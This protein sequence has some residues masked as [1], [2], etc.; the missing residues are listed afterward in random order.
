MNRP[1]NVLSRAERLEKLTEAGKWHE[2]DSIF[3][4]PKVKGEIKIKK[5]K[6]K[7]KKEEEEE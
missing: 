5:A 2:G 6:K 4:L 3:N 1:R 7:K